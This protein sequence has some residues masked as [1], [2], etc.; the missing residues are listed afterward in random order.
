MRQASAWLN[1]WFSP[2]KTKGKGSQLSVQQRIGNFLLTYQSANH[3]TT[4]RTPANL[5]LG[6]DSRSRLTLLRPTTGEKVMDSQAKQKATPDVH[7]K[8]RELY[9]G[10]RIW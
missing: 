10:D 3:P 1:E 6:R 5:F 9:P 4:G 7:A 2:S 8:F